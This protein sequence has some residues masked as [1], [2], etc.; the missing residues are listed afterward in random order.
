MRSKILEDALKNI[1][2]FSKKNKFYEFILN[3]ANLC[4]YDLKLQKVALISLNRLYFY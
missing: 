4:I 2:T 3:N 1:R